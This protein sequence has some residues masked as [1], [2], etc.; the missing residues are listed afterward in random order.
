MLEPAS[1][2]LLLDAFQPP[3]DHTLDWAVGTTYSLDLTALLSAPVAFAF[4]ACQDRDGRPLMEPLV[5]L[6]AVRQYAD[7][8]C[9]FCQAGR[10]HV[11]QAYQPLLAYLEHSIFE[12]IA[13]AGGSFHP[14]VWFLRYV[15]A[16]GKVTYRFLCL[17]RNLTFDRSWDTMLSLDGKLR[18]RVN[19]YSSN[20]VLGEFVEALPKMVPRKVSSEWK[21]R[22]KQLAYEVRRVEFEIPEPF[23][24]IAFW[25][26]GLTGEETWPFPH[27]VKKMLVISPFVDDGLLSDLSQWAVPLQLVSRAESL[28]EI[29]PATLESYDKVWILDDTAEPE[30]TD[31]DEPRDDNAGDAGRP[32]KRS[33]L[34]EQIPLVG[35][36]AK[37]YVADAGWDSHLYTG[38]ANATQAGF[39]RN[40]EFLVELVGKRSRCGVDA[41]LGQAQDGERKAAACL[42]DLLQPFIPADRKQG[43]DI[44]TERFERLV[45][46]LARK[47]AAVVPTAHCEVLETSESFT[48]RLN[49]DQRVTG[50][51]TADFLLRVRPISL[52]DAH[53][54]PLDLGK[55]SW[56]CFSPVSLLGLTSFY[57]IEASSPNRAITRQFVLNIP[58]ENAPAG[59]H[60]KILNHLLSDSNR[61]MRFL[62]LLLM[63]HDAR[64]LDRLVV[65]NG[66]GNGDFG[67]FGSMFDATLFES[68]M[69][70]IDRDPERIDQVASLIE[71]LQRTP[72]GREL[73][74]ADLETIWK[75]I[76]KV[77]Q[78]Q[79]RRTNNG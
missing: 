6:K 72:E 18:D 41:I 75:P 32:D 49:A 55:K 64:D 4:A 20:H 68:M 30:P 21:K 9:L 79:N 73:L 66:S 19:A 22:L 74:P 3:A 13:P 61:V 50:I 23:H 76:W 46:K 17:S 60:Q 5:L 34:D 1:R 11:P 59:R 12:A 25:P 29:K 15:S 70:A 39:K 52:P 38:S 78:Q 44:E 57:V 8:V 16:D 26:M 2:R 7:R 43:K 62:M 27:R 47:L 24:E 63:D 40:V 58:L 45:E 69:R 56:A 42:A 35:L 65:N 10:I 53:L 71:D 67:V 54:Q 31:E 51:N 77:R 36:H 14:K 33:G 28:A 48:V 37:L